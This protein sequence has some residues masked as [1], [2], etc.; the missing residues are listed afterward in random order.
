MKEITVNEADYVF[1]AYEE[2]EGYFYEIDNLSVVEFDE[3]IMEITEIRETDYELYT[4]LLEEGSTEPAS[5]EVE[6][7]ND[8][9]KLSVTM[10]KVLMQNGDIL[11]LPVLTDERAEF[12]GAN[13]SHGSE[14]W[15]YDQEGKREATD[16]EIDNIED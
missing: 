9:D 10:F 1:Y 11:S 15:Y 7:F 16:D 13:P 5:Y 14:Y 8:G 6:D 3:N 4:M 2:D 12:I